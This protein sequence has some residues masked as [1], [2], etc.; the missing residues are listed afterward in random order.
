M[1]VTKQVSDWLRPAAQLATCQVWDSEALTLFRLAVQTV[2]GFEGSSRAGAF[3]RL[4]FSV[5]PH[6]FDAL[7]ISYAVVTDAF[8]IWKT[9]TQNTSVT[10]LFVG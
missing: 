6:C 8:A 9:V 10:M 5:L 7:L 4:A 3:S 1:S 2:S